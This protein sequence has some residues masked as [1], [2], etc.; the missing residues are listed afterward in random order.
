MVKYIGY[1]IGINYYKYNNATC[2]NSYDVKISKKWWLNIMRS[3]NVLSRVKVMT[4]TAIK[5]LN[6][7]KLDTLILFS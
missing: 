5:R 1:I 2:D 7:M 3:M 6:I 4:H